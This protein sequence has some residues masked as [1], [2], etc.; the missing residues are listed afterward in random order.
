MSLRFHAAER[1]GVHYGLTIVL[2]VA[3]WFV[4]ALRFGA[5]TTA[6]QQPSLVPPAAISATNPQRV[7]AGCPVAGDLVG[8]ANPAV[9][10]Q[11]L[12]R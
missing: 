3:I 1:P 10:A 9:V 4:L 7:S 2:V 8:D 11:A 5:P 6:E 12:C